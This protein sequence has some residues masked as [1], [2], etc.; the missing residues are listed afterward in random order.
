MA[1]GLVL[2]TALGGEIFVQDYFYTVYDTSRKDLIR[3]Y[4]AGSELIY[5]GLLVKGHE[6]L[7]AFFDELPATKHEVHS[8][9]CQPVRSADPSAPPNILVSVNGKVTFA[10]RDKRRFHQTILLSH[11]AESNYT[12]TSDCVRFTATVE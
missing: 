12:V 9:D 5:N 6:A 1:E 4:N 3:F 8:L 10:G 2:Q 11:V 7:R